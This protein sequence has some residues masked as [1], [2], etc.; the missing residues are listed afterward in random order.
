MEL[1]RRY[2]PA[3]CHLDGHIAE[4]MVATEEIEMRVNGREFKY[5]VPE[6]KQWIV[7]ISLNIKEVDIPPE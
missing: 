5:E 7:G 6:G 3:A 4:D 2:I 1:S